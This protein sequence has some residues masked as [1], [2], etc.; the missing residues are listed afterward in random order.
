M[1]TN[2]ER[3][4]EYASKNNLK[5]YEVGNILGVGHSTFYA[6]YM[7]STDEKKLKYVIDAIDA[8]LKGDA[9]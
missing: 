7:Q 5:M 6:T 8:Y 1:I 2:A 3:I 4:K 9:E